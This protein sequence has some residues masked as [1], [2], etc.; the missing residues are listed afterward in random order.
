M[1]RNG[2]TSNRKSRS[3]LCAVVLLATAIGTTA[4][5]GGLSDRSIKGNWG[6]SALGT[7]MPPAF[8]TPTPA[9]A[10]GTIEFD[11]IGGCFFTDTI[12]LGGLALSR[13]STSCSYAVYADGSGTILVSFDGDPGPTPLSF[14][15]VDRAREIQFI[16][17]DL[18]VARGTA[19]RIRR[20]A[21]D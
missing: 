5:A 9:A 10:V 13:S 18:G 11:G 21:N 16:R 1:N 12:N 3:A 6:F 7:I 15:V 19:K 14:V 8:P 17:T 4:S 20:A 2:Q